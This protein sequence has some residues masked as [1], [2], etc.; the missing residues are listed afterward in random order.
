MMNTE[1]VQRQPGGSSLSIAK[2]RS[3]YFSNWAYV[4]K[5]FTLKLLTILYGR[6]THISQFHYP[7]EEHLNG[8]GC[9]RLRLT[10]HTSGV[11]AKGDGK[12]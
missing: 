12:S 4:M 1:H 2:N 5:D 7:S 9:L 6:V 10:L 8:P 3:S 11:V